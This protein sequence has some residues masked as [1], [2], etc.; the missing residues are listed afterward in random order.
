MEKNMKT[1]AK[2]TEIKSKQILISGERVI[3]PHLN[4][5]EQD[6]PEL[7]KIVK[8]MMMKRYTYLPK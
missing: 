4:C 6:D 8:V 7:I 3:Q 1:Q 2:G 5:K